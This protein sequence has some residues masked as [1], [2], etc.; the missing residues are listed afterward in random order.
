[1]S[2]SK[3]NLTAKL[4]EV[5]RQLSYWPRTLRLIW[6]GAPKW[7]SAWA[8][9]LVIQGILP[10]L[11]VYLTK[12]LVDHLVLAINAKGQWQEVWPTLILVGITATVML[13]ADVLQ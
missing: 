7:T 10:A 9:L 1:M 2:L 3:E 13:L 11:S 8:V 12:L 4:K 6:Q 5:R